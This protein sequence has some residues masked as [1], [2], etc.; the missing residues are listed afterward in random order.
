MGY[1][2]CAL[3]RVAAHH[4]MHAQHTRVREYASPRHKPEFDLTRVY[5]VQNGCMGTSLYVY[6]SS[7]RH[8]AFADALRLVLNPAYAG[9]G[10]VNPL[11]REPIIGTK[12]N[13]HAAKA[14]LKFP[15]GVLRGLAG[16]QVLHFVFMRVRPPTNGQTASLTRSSESQRDPHGTAAACHADRHH[17]AGCGSYHG[18]RS[19]ACGFPY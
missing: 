3:A 18:G 16:A 10:D 17:D 11:E 1:W 12:P 13:G 9:H 2:L 8:D 5:N 6:T 7:A 14:D 19:L 4:V 15:G